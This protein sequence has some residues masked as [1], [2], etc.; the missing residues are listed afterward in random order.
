MSE[1][2]N[3][4]LGATAPDDELLDVLE[5]VRSYIMGRDDPSAD[6]YCCSNIVGIVLDDPTRV[7]SSELP[8]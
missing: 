1:V 5:S 6:I 4:R 8:A 3:K 2:E 7:S